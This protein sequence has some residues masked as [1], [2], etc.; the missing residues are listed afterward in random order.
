MQELTRGREA[1]QPGRRE[2]SIREICHDLR[3][4]IATI[5][6]LAAAAM[7]Q[8]NA[9]P[10]SAGGPIVR[11]R[12]EQIQEETRRMSQL[13]RQ[14]LEDA[15]TPTL[16]DAAVIAGDVAASCRVTFPGTIQ[17]MASAGA[18]VVVD[19]VGL[20]RSLANLVENATRAAGPEGSVLVRVRRA[21][22]WIHCEVSDSGPGFGKGPSG[23]QSLGLTIVDRLAR[24]HG[25]RLEVLDS[26]LGGAML[27]LSLPLAELN[28][29]L[30]NALP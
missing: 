4:P 10:D 21:R 7:T 13:V 5:S 18:M 17:V 11:K 12:L 3:N 30:G 15:T 2:Q 8:L 9:P 29:S 24:S 23:S 22:T 28:G 25:G 16:L 26:T 1:A 6:A 27:R 20:R 19:E 14:L